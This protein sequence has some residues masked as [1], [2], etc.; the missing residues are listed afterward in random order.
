MDRSET[1]ISQAFDAIAGSR[2]LKGSVKTERA[3]VHVDR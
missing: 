1:F 3:S 2:V